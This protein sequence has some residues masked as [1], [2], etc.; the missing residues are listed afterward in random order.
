MKI[1]NISG[2]ILVV[3]IGDIAT[4]LEVGGTATFADTEA[5]NADF[6]KL[7]T[8]GKIKIVDSGSAVGANLATTAR[9]IGDTSFVLKA[10]TG[11][12]RISPGDKFTIA[13]DTTVYT[14]T[15]GLDVDVADATAAT[16]TFSPPLVVAVAAA[17]FPLITI[18]SDVIPWANKA[19]NFYVGTINVTGVPSTT[20]TLTV[21]GVVFEFTATATTALTTSTN[22]RI[23]IAG[24]TATTIA[25]AVRDGI[26]ASTVLKALGV[27]AVPLITLADKSGL[28]ASS[29]HCITVTSPRDVVLT[30]ADTAAT[31]IVTYVATTGANILG[32]YHSSSR[33][34]EMFKVTATGTT[35]SIYTGFTAIESVITQVNLST[36]ASSL[37]NGVVTTFGGWINL[38]IGA[39][40]ANA[41]TALASGQTI[42]LLVSG[43]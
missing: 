14:V 4:R 42:T 15:S 25:Q 11:T 21:Q 33:R 7:S 40:L 12:G 28:G 10:S 36:G 30:L 1:K 2:A 37:Y 20:E 39:T 29:D 8:S 17:A 24:A 27:V 16:I 9:S 41:S 34:L 43:Y 13:G 32:L 3:T 18:V 22:T 23:S 38:A 26:N 5:A 35:Q 19:A 6:L 31:T